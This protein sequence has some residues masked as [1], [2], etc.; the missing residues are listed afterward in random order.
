MSVCGLSDHLHCL[1]RMFYI[2]AAYCFRG[3]METHIHSHFVSPQ[4]WHIKYDF[5]AVGFKLVKIRLKHYFH[6]PESAL[7]T[8]PKHNMMV[9]IYPYIALFIHFRSG[10]CFLNNVSWGIHCRGIKGEGCLNSTL[11][12]DTLWLTDL[13]LVPHICVSESG[14]QWF[15]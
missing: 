8:I 4:T 10:R 9:T 14:H 6:W 13:P 1:G 15:R 7:C 12:Y 2:Q 11:H 5:V 3:A